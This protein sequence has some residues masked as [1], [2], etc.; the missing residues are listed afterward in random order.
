MALAIAVFLVVQSVLIRYAN[1]ASAKLGERVLAELRE[2]FVDRVLDLPLSMVERAGTGDLLTRTSRDVDA[3]SRSV[4]FAVPKIL[5][6]AVTVVLTVGA[7]LVLVRC[8][9]L[10]CLLACRS[11]WSRPRWYLSRARE[12]YLREN[13]AY[14]DMTDGLA[15]TVEGARTVEALRGIGP[16]QQRA[17]T[18]IAR[19][20]RGRA[21]HAVPA[22]R[23]LAVHGV[24]YLLPLVGTL[25]FGG[26]STRTAGSAWAR[27]PRRRCTCS[28]SSTR[29]TGCSPGS[30]SS[31]SAAPRWPGC[32]AFGEV[33][34][35]RSGRSRSGDRR[36]RARTGRHDVRYSYVAGRD[37]LH[38]VDLGAP[39]ERL[40]MV[41]P[42]GAGKSTLGRLLAGIHGPTPGSVDVG[43]VPL[44]EL[45]LG[46]LRGQVALVNQE[47]HVFI[48]T[49]RENVVLARP[50]ATDAE[51]R[52]A[53]AAVDALAWVRRLPWVWTPGRGSP[54]SPC[55]R[56]RR[57]S[58]RWP[59]WSWPTRTRWSWTRPP[60]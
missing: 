45:P 31:R 12:G 33:H 2:N 59:G 20:F 55:R 42:S 37:V 17:Q 58:S 19:S 40:A 11:W 21:L 52:A 28:S 15:E 5:V 38:G 32:S 30:T 25:L 27:S 34:R 22:L 50:H 53:L 54:S 60:R 4:R 3:L 39:G 6:A 48:G 10:P 44:V 43:G 23:L 41:G 14:S 36:R 49:L 1:L 13:A 35:R 57:S 8:S 16:P 7:L 26:W 29:S 24:G 18:D 9:A 56:P 47:H 46:E 51:V